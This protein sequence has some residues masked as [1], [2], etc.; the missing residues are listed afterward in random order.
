MASSILGK[1]GYSSVLPL[2]QLVLIVLTLGLSAG[3]SFNAGEGGPAPAKSGDGEG[4]G[5]RSQRLVL[6]PEQE[7]SLGQQAY[8]Q[9]LAKAHVVKGGRDVDRV[10][11]VAERIVKAAEIEPLQR[12]VNYR[13]QGYRWDW[14]FNVL[15]EK[16]VNAFCL[17]GGKVAVFS[18]LL[19]VTENDDQ[20]A[21]VLGHE[22]A[23]ALAHHANERIAREQYQ[24]FALKAAAGVLGQI[25][26]EHA[27]KLVM[28]LGGVNQ[29]RGMAYDRRQES[30]ADHIGIF[31]MTFAKYNP[32]EAL[33]FWQRMEAIGSRQGHP[34]EILS[35]HPSDA[36][37][38]AEIGKWI[39]NAK[40]AKQALDEGR[41]APR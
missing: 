4:P 21:V 41:V 17:P 14:E 33:R 38:I 2:K 15:E 23:H 6:S 28:L 35:D 8:K 29:V 11:H 22:I 19:P 10:R 40:A 26:R 16:Q 12:E 20:L 9:V 5:H 37:R 7:Y 36:H 30:E 25:D 3:C 1:P 24:E 27:D 18:G 31:L 32:D 13:L 34:P 39:P